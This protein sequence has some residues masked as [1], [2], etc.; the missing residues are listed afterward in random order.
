M[1]LPRPLR[2]F[3]Q[4]FRYA[5]ACKTSFFFLLKKT[6]RCAAKGGP[7]KLENRKQV[8]PKGIKSYFLEVLQAPA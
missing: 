7:P 6:L 8:A 3:F 4:F 2:S 1:K 5:G